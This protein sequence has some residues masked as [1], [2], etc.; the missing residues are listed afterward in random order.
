MSE[1][2]EMLTL[3]ELGQA[4]ISAEIAREAYN[5]A[6]ERLADVLDTKKVFEQKAQAFFAGYIT[7]ALALFGYA[8]ALM[9]DGGF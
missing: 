7:L 2:P 1:P 4:S 3:E 8:A 6:S 9:S 5:H